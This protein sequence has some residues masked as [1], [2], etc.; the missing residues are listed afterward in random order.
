MDKRKLAGIVLLLVALVILFRCSGETDKQEQQKKTQEVDINRD[1]NLENESEEER[2]TVEQEAVPVIEITGL[3]EEALSVLDVSLADVADQVK[4]WADGNG[5]TGID[6]AAFYNIMTIDFADG[7][8]SVE[9][10]LI[11]GTHGNGLLQDEQV[12]TMDYF[13]EDGLFQFH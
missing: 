1:E 5:H 11:Q 12:Y 10:R 6:G 8:Y 9:F 2:K 7:K 4:D 13:S 3:T